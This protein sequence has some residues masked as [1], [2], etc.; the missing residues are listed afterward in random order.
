MSFE[1]SLILPTKFG[2]A[3]HC[4]GFPRPSPKSALA[5]VCFAVHAHRT[6]RCKSLGL[7][8]AKS[9]PSRSTTLPSITR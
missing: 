8:L 7:T 6:L 3:G 5:T 9:A 4:A 2:S 1:V